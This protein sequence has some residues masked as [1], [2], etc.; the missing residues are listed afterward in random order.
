MVLLCQAGEPIE[1]NLLE[2]ESCN[3]EVISSFFDE[4]GFLKVIHRYTLIWIR[5]VAIEQYVASTE[6]H[7]QL[8]SNV[9]VYSA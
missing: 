9:Y 8:L 5:K 1:A 7:F 2:L 4:S 3:V 6:M